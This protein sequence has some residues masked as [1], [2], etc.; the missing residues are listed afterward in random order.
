MNRGKY[1]VLLLASL[2]FTLLLTLRP[3]G[4][5][6][7]ADGDGTRVSAD[8]VSTDP[9]VKSDIADSVFSAI[10]SNSLIFVSNDH[11][12]DIVQYGCRQGEGVCLVD[13]RLL[14]STSYR[15]ELKRKYGVSTEFVAETST[16][17]A[18]VMYQLF[19]QSSFSKYFLIEDKVIAWTYPYICLDGYLPELSKENSGA[20]NT[21]TED[22]WMRLFDA[23]VHEGGLQREDARLL[24]VLRM[25]SG[26]FYYT[27][28]AKD[29]AWLA[30]RDAIILDPTNEEAL[31]RLIDYLAREKRYAEAETTIYGRLAAIDLELAKRIGEALNSSK[32]YE[33][34]KKEQLRLRASGVRS[35][36]NK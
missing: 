35:T 28:G 18:Q 23:L 1:S 30:Y 10:P 17:W 7:P 19:M 33:Q 32:D 25:T 29:L 22:V 20:S 15:E 31:V 34:W 12:Q 6:A 36:D 8:V 11:L 4:A 2:F 16:N 26:S 24:S 27:R 14:S 5:G 21:S 9:S 3:M 13:P